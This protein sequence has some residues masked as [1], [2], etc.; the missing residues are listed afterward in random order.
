MIK[1]ENEC[2]GCP[3]EMGCLGSSC[4]YRDVPHFYCDDCGEEIDG[5]VY[6]DDNYEHCCLDCLLRHH[7]IEVIL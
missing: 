2:V 7:K 5:E 6:E 1:Y 3:P 4:S